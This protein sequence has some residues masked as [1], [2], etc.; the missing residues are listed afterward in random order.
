MKISAGKYIKNSLV[1]FV[2]LSLCFGISILLQILETE[3]PITTVFVFGVF[4]ISLLTD[5]Y[6]YGIVSAFV[7]VFAV[8][9]AFTFPYFSFNFTIPEN[10]VSAIVMIVI[11]FMTSALMTKQK[12]WQALKAD[13]ERET[14]RATL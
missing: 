11:S 6:F 10:L 1:S 8:N 13:A 5:G 3:K 4:L 12:K 2:V 14:M 7:S 9:F